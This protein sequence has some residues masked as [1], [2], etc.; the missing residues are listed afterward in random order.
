L[1]ACRRWNEKTHARKTCAQF[2]AHFSAAHHQY[3]QMQGESTST[4]SYHS[5]NSTVG[6]T[7]DQM[8]EAAIGDLSNLATA[9][10]SDPG[11]VV[12]LT[13]ANARLAR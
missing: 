11:V 4:S 6:Q 5:A 9:T 13:E 3:K 12:T 2:K 1:S 8:Y 10:A 7:G